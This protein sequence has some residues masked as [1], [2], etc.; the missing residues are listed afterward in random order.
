MPT[1]LGSRPTFSCSHP[2]VLSHKFH[3]KFSG[4]D[5]SSR[6]LSFRAERGIC[7]RRALGNSRSLAPLGMT[8]IQR[9]PA[10]FDLFGEFLGQ[11]TSIRPIVLEECCSGP[12]FRG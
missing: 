9:L 8:R 3:A 11:N 12:S 2:S 6:P 4:S 10:P 7:W 5:D 1:G